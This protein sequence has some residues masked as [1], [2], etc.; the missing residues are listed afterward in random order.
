MND[1]DANN[2]L[3]KGNFPR[4]A[5]SPKGQDNK[6]SDETSFTLVSYQRRAPARTGKSHE[7]PQV[8]RMLFQEVTKGKFHV[9]QKDVYPIIRKILEE[10][11]DFNTTFSR[12]WRSGKG[13]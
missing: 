10:N 4:R 1:L 5:V 2:M 6:P 3:M 11:K 12:N 9:F 7:N 13:Q 8:T